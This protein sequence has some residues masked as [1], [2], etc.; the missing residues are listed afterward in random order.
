MLHALMRVLGELSLT[1]IRP[2]L[3]SSLVSVTDEN[4]CCTLC[5]K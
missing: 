4:P 5:L 1:A 3:C 2:H